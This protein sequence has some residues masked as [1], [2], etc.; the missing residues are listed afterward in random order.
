MNVDCSSSVRMWIELL[1]ELVCVNVDCSSS[2]ARLPSK[3]LQSSTT[4]SMTH[5]QCDA[6]TITLSVRHKALSASWSALNYSL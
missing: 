1:V 5:G 6:G 3:G 4:E 2:G